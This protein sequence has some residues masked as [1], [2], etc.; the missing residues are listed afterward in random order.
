MT[1]QNAHDPRTPG[2]LMVRATDIISE[3]G[4]QWPRIRQI[5]GKFI[6][7]NSQRLPECPDGANKAAL[8]LSI[9]VFEELQRMKAEM[10]TSGYGRYPQEPVRFRPNVDHSVRRA[11][12]E[13][14]DA[15]FHEMDQTGDRSDDR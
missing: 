7:G 4:N 10:E 11:G 8:P 15:E 1:K 9:D 3:I 14:E 5:V 12:D 2:R 6:T 13:V